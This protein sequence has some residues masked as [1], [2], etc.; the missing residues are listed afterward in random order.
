MIGEFLMIKKP[1]KLLAT[2]VTFYNPNRI[3]C[4]FH[5][6]TFASIGVVSHFN[7]SH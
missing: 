1:T 4:E 7:I 3:V 6:F 5:L 2:F